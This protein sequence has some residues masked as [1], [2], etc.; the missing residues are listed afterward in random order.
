MHNICKWRMNEKDYL[1]KHTWRVWKSWRKTLHTV[2]CSESTHLCC[3]DPWPRQSSPR[4]SSETVCQTE[5]SESVEQ[6]QN[7]TKHNVN[8]ERFNLIQL[9]RIFTRSGLA[10]FSSARSTLVKTKMVRLPPGSIW[11][12]KSVWNQRNESMQWQWMHTGSNYR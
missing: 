2:W 8:N 1:N 9:N 12:T 6:R 10:R 11:A 7:K 3:L 5:F 4:L